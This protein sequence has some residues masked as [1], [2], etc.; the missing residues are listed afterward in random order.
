M[1]KKCPKCL[2]T[3]IDFYAAAMTGLYHCKKCGYIGVI[4]IEEDIKLK[5]D[6]RK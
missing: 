1:T 5:N 2:S 3:R 6:S 4:I